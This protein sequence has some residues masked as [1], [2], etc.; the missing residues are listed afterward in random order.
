MYGPGSLP[1][2]LHDQER[3]NFYAEPLSLQGA[4][5]QNP[6]CVAILIQPQHQDLATGDSFLLFCSVKNFVKP[7]DL[8][9]NWYRNNTFV[10]SNSKFMRADVNPREHQGDYYCVIKS[11][12]AGYSPVRSSTCV[13]NIAQISSANIERPQNFFATDKVA[14]LIGNGD[15]R[16]HRR[17][18]E[19][20]NDLEKLTDILQNELNFK[21]LSF[22]NLSCPEMHKAF[23]WF[24][25][26]ASEGCYCV[27][28]FGGHGFQKDGKTYLMPVDATESNYHKDCLEADWEL[29][30][31]QRRC[32][33]SLTLALLDTCRRRQKMDYV[34]RR[35]DT[36]FLSNMV[37]AYATTESREAYE[38]TGSNY[39]IFVGAL[40]NHLT[41]PVRVTHML[42]YV[43]EDVKESGCQI[44]EVRQTLTEYRCLTDEIKPGTHFD[45]NHFIWMFMHGKPSMPI[46]LQYPSKT[47]AMVRLTVDYILTNAVR[48]SL[49]VLNKGKCQQCRAGIDIRRLNKR[50]HVVC[51][52]QHDIYPECVDIYHSQHVLMKDG[53]LPVPVVLVYVIPD[54]P[55]DD[56]CGNHVHRYPLSLPFTHLWQEKRS[57]AEYSASFSFLIPFM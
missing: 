16:Y 34:L 35:P 52:D 39:G 25:E 13:V 24:S 44:S 31:I 36:S 22:A 41:K 15:Y 50:A 51:R 8:I 12:I 26:L 45:R 19:A 20:L 42:D 1:A 38:G 18:P 55:P 3:S 21:T 33:P 11:R 2:Q 28:Y 6:P 32:S 23:I 57:L 56:A 17:L 10:E 54:V 37:I 9:F 46:K 47:D 4:G 30:N 40:Q 43:Q 5:Q 27:F 7:E 49:K 53:R 14:L 48:L 29:E